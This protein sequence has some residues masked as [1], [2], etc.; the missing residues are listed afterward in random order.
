MA[1][2]LLHVSVTKCPRKKLW[3]RGGLGLGYLPEEGE[4]RVRV[5]VRVR[6]R[7]PLVPE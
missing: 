2:I 6:A 7:E 3:G 1:L 5:R 4:V